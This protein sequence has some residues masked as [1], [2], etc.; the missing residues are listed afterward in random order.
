[1]NKKRVQWLWRET[2]LKVLA[3][4]KY[5]RRRLVTTENSCTRERAEYVDHVWSYAFA[6]H[7]TENGRSG[8]PRGRRT[9]QSRDDE[10]SE[11]RVQV[12]GPTLTLLPTEVS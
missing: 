7:A 8:F 3:S 12:P 2:G 4:R 10:S 9:L 6:M 1:M 5:K 11:R